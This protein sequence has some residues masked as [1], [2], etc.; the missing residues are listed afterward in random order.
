LTYP[1]GLRRAGEHAW[2]WAP[3]KAAANFHRGFIRLRLS[4]V[5]GSGGNTPI[6]P[7]GYDPLAELNFLGRAVLALFD[8]PGAICYFNPNGEVLLGRERFQETW[9]GC[10]ALGK[11]PLSLW[12]N[13]RFFNLSDQFTFMDTVG[14]GQVDVA[15]AEAIFP[16]SKYDAN[17]VGYYLGNVTHYLLDFDDRITSGDPIDGPG[18]TNLSWTAEWHE[19]GLVQPPRRVLRLYPTAN[20]D[21]VRRAL[22]A[23]GD[24]AS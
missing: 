13:T 23:S 21:E 2:A 24:T 22:D 10:A 18:E 20:R 3:G 14:N 6:L 7:E 1:G 9:S 5:F 15:D 8:V 19:E 4:Y 11:I 17:D 16:K 12:V